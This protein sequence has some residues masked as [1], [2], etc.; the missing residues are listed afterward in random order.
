MT[1]LRARLAMLRG[2]NAMKK[3][4]QG[5]TALPDTAQSSIPSWA[6]SA[7]AAPPRGVNSCGEAVTTPP[8]AATT[9]RRTLYRDYETRSVLDLSKCG[10]AV[11]AAHPLTDVWCCAYAV[12]AGPVQL[13]VPG[14]PAPPEF[15]E[16]ECNPDWDASAFND[17]FERQ[18]ERCIMHPRYGFPI[19]PT[20]RHKCTQAQ[21]L[22]AA[23][24]GDLDMAA[25]ALGLEHQ[26]GDTALMKEVSKPRLPR[27][28]ENSTGLYWCDDPEK[29]ARL[30]AYCVRDVEVE[31]ELHQRLPR[32]SA[33]EQRVWVLDAQINDRG[34]FTDAKL[35]NGAI[36]TVEI[37]TASIKTE[38]KGITGLD[39]LNSP[40]KIRAWLKQRGCELPNLKRDTVKAA[41]DS[42]TDLEVRRVLELRLAGARAAVK[43]LTRFSMNRGQDGRV[44]GAFR[45]HGAATGRWSSLGI[46]VHNLKRPETKDLAPVIEAISAGEERPLS[47]VAD[48]LRAIICAAPDHKLLGADYSGVESRITAWVSGQQSKIDAWAKFDQTRN[49]EDEPYYILG[50][51]MKL[52]RAGGKTCDLAFGYMG[53]VPAYRNLAPQSTLTD[54]EIKHLQRQWRALHPETVGFWYALD[55]GAKEA[56]TTAN[57]VVVVNNKISFI[58]ENKTLWMILPSGRRIAYPGAYLKQT[59]R[60]DA[61]VFFDNAAGGWREYRKGR[62]AYGGT[63]IENAVQ[64]IARDIFA[65]AMLRLDAAGFQI[66]MHVHDEMVAEV[67]NGFNAGG[68]FERIITEVPDWASGLPIRANTREGSRFCKT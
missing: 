55:R 43:K 27:P 23:Y 66:C 57:K 48:I 61:V 7:N 59:D 41:L 20:E 58:F 9:G 46:Q 39:S 33:E 53:S 52:D 5:G 18:I 15:I 45:Y 26:K 1:D 25:K 62:G 34:F 28:N 29:L 17:N 3:T 16:A 12:D 51:L 35:L 14:N 11:Y 36:Q 50:A 32:L 60:E 10:A 63:L 67:R 6:T 54:K 38:F 22:A 19:I 47:E 65:A 8:A 68:E 13:W 56:I 4:P 21:T 40:Q 44:R 42:A 30:Y 24:P 64:G 49:E 2:A 31:R 37:T